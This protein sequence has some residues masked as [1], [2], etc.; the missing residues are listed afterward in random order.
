MI[1]PFPF[2]RPCRLGPFRRR[3]GPFG[4]SIEVTPNRDDFQFDLLLRTLNS[5]A[6]RDAAKKLAEHANARK[7]LTGK[8][9]DTMRFHLRPL[10]QVTPFNTTHRRR[11]N[12]MFFDQ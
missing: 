8:P 7:Q 11:P 6:A 1:A 2:W 12:Q 5:A 4:F 9:A 3:S 10:S